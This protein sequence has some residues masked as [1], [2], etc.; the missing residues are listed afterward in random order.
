MKRYEYNKHET[1]IINHSTLPQLINII[2]LADLSQS[3]KQFYKQLV[4]PVAIQKHEVD[5]LST[6]AT[7][8]SANKH[9]TV[10]HAE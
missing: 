2:S 8:S 3:C 4:Q 1:E 6:A 9:R 5:Q 7:N 10:K